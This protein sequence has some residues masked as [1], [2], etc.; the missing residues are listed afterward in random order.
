MVD[1][2]IYKRLRGATRCHIRLQV[3][4]MHDAVL[5]L[6]LLVLYIARLF[7]MAR[8][9]ESPQT[10]FACIILCKYR[11]ISAFTRRATMSLVVSGEDG[12]M[13]EQNE[14]EKKEWTENEVRKR[15]GALHRNILLDV[16]APWVQWP[17]EYGGLLDMYHK[18]SKK[19]WIPKS[20]A[21]AKNRWKI[22]ESKDKIQLFLLSFCTHKQS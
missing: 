6:S 22:L 1:F 10:H 12:G 15:R 21:S 20:F 17:H 13:S 3:T 18:T 14:R 7:H 16:N 4:R 8:R 5:C 2:L 19:K 11:L 9:D